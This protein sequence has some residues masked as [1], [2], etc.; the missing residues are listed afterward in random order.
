MS[1]NRF[2]LLIRQSPSL[3]PWP[4][5]G[6]RGLPGPRRDD[7][8]ARRGWEPS[9]RASGS[10][11]SRTLAGEAGHGQ[12]EAWGHVDRERVPSTGAAVGCPEHTP[13]PQGTAPVL[14]V[15]LI[16]E[17]LFGEGSGAAVGVKERW[18][19]EIVQKQRGAGFFGS[20][21]VFAWSCWWGL[22]S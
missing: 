1:R 9:G 10:P 13:D 6:A 16:A 21:C 2:S 8:G 19:R 11:G 12:Q 5:A 14:C 22:G 18:R 7:T 17:V 20:G 3:V 15:Q 4:S